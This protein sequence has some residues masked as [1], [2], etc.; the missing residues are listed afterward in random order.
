MISLKMNHSITAQIV[1]MTVG[2]IVKNKERLKDM[3]KKLETLL[4][5]EKKVEIE[6]NR[7]NDDLDCM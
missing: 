2:M 3:E 5:K 1:Q 6:I 4:S 7:I